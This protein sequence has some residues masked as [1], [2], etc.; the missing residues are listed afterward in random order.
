MDRKEIARRLIK[1]RAGRSRKE[2]AE[3]VG[4]SVTAIQNYEY[5]LRIPCD[6][7]KVRLAK[8]FGV[9]VEELFYEPPGH[10]TCSEQKGA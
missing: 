5:G 8:Y 6:D 3:A 4:V 2:V 1:L 9:S 7:I 10:K